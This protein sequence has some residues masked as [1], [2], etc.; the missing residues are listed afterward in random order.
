MSK[1]AIADKISRIA[2]DENVPVFGIGPAS[3][4]ADEKLG[5]RPEDLLPGT[6]SLICFGIPVPEGVY[7]MPTYGLETAWRSQNLHYRR[8]DALSMRFATLLEES[9]EKAVEY[10]WR[11]NGRHPRFCAGILRNSCQGF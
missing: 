5:H 6:K 4:M 10:F 8:L 7:H 11:A 3:A 1:K 2:K 9:G